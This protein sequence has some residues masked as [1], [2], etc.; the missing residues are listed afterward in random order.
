V[1]D[2]IAEFRALPPEAR[3]VA[4]RKAREILAAIGAA[5]LPGLDVSVSE[6]KRVALLTR[7]E[8]MEGHHD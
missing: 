7:L 4:L 5:S 2:L 6:Q 8:L 1:D 3:A